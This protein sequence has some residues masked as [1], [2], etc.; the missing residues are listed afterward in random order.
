MSEMDSDL[1]DQEWIDVLIEM[2]KAGVS[3]EEFKRFIEQEKQKR[4]QAMK[5]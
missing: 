3:K 2:I 1:L 5:S 4:R